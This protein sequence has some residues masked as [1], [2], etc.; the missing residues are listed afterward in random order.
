MK[1]LQA[2]RERKFLVMIEIEREHFHQKAENIPAK[3][4]VERHTNPKTMQNQ[5]MEATK[6]LSTL[7]QDEAQAGVSPTPK[8]D[9]SISAGASK[10]ADSTKKNKRFIPD[11]KKPDAALTFPEK[12]RDDTAWQLEVSRQHVLTLFSFP[13]LQL[14]SLMKTADKHDPK[15]FCVAWLPDGKTFIIRDPDEFTRKVLLNFFKA[16]KFSS[17]TRK[18]YRWGFRQVNRGI[19]PDDPIIFGNECFQR[20]D[21]ELMKN[22]RSITAAS[23]RKQEKSSLQVAMAQKAQLEEADREKNR[24]LLDRIL[25]QKA[26]NSHP[27]LGCQTNALDMSALAAL[28]TNMGAPG[29]GLNMYDILEQRMHR[30]ALLGAIPLGQPSMLSALAG[31]QSY[32]RQASTAD[33]LNAAMGALRYAP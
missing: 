20:D 29:Y 24:A 33:I 16:T 11:H 28:R 12:V 3:N 13:N 31:G 15:T 7:K 5:T 1:R 17:F 27:M 26:L 19:G 2:T 10:A 8:P 30:N 32:Q 25:Q 22:M 23:A 18:L 6:S 21:E 9:D 4:T 14:M